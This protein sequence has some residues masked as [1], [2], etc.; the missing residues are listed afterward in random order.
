M[1][2]LAEGTLAAGAHEVAWDGRDAQ[3]RTVP[4]GLYFARLTTEYGIETRK[5]AL[6]K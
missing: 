5:L 2:V 3:G 6:L 1:R 4:S